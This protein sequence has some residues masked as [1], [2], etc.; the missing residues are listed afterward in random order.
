MLKSIGNLTRYS[1]R[2][3]SFGDRLVASAQ[4]AP[5]A[6]SKYD[7]F[8]DLNRSQTYSINWFSAL[9]LTLTLSALGLV[10]LI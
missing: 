10:D 9:G 3:A 7:A 8:H 4:M 1:K 6:V 2:Q 5:L